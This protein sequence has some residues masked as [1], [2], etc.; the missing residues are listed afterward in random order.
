M[1]LKTSFILFCVYLLSKLCRTSVEKALIAA[2]SL[3]ERPLQNCD[4]LFL[5]NKKNPCR[6]RQRLEETWKKGD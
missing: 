1:G 4:T 6:L 3:K 5:I 2:F